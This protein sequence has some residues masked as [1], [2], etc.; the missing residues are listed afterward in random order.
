MPL[1][2]YVGRTLFMIRLGQLGGVLR[3]EACLGGL[4]WG[5]ARIDTI[6]RFCF[7]RRASKRR[8]PSTNLKHGQ[9]AETNRTA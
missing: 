7:V 1:D 3:F 8:K 4:L 5:A 2:E 6:Q 9:S